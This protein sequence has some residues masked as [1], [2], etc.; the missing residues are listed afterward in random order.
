LN[1]FFY[2]VFPARSRHR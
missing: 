1:I 2:L